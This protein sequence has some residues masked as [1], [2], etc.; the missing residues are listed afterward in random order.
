MLTGYLLISIFLF[1][2]CSR[3]FP[4]ISGTS[5]G[6]TES[7]PET[8]ILTRANFPGNQASLIHFRGKFTRF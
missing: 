6:F 4:A 8:K 7:N 2:E 3:M 1:I 5:H